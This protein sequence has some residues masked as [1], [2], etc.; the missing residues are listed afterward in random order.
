[1]QHA[2][3]ARIGRIGENRDIPYFCE[4]RCTMTPT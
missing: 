4:P 3:F 1:M 2:M